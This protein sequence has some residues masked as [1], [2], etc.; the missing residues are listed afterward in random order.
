VIHPV[1]S[2]ASLPSAFSPAWA[3]V[4]IPLIAAV[5]GLLNGSLQKER[6]NMYTGR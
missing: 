6:G 5:I 4:L 2:L 3:S 1:I